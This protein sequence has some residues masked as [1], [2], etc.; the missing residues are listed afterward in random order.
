M[1]YF[2]ESSNGSIRKKSAFHLTM[3]NMHARRTDREDPMTGS[4]IISAAN[5]EYQRRVVDF[6]HDDGD[7]G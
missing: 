2:G 3:R 4:Q 5:A 7:E 1:E 6:L